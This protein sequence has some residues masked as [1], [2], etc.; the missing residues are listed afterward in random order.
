MKNDYPTSLFQYFGI[1]K[2]IC[3]IMVTNTSIVFV[4]LPAMDISRA[5]P[6]LHSSYKPLGY[7][8][9]WQKAMDCGIITGWRLIA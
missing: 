5:E 3:Q 1:C 6:T 7:R 4:F 8:L 2:V 9:K